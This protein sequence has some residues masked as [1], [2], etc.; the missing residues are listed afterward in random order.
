MPMKEKEKG[1]EYIGQG[2][3]GCVFDHQIKCE[4]NILISK[5]PKI[6]YSKVFDS[7]EEA[8]I[9]WKNSKIIA[10]IDPNYDS[11]VYCFEKCTTNYDEVKKD[12]SIQKC[13]LHFYENTITILKMPYGGID[14][15]KYITTQNPS[16][17][18]FI[19]SIIPLFEGL[20]KLKNINIVHQDVKADNV[21]YD[22]EKNIWRFIDY[23]ILTTTNKIYIKN[24]LHI[25][26][27]DYYPAP[28]EYR[29]LTK[30]YK[31]KNTS[32]DPNDIIANENE[33]YNLKLSSDS[34]M[35]Y[36]DLIHIYMPKIEYETSLVNFIK[37]LKNFNTTNIVSELNKYTSKI[38]IY[39]LGLV[40]MYLTLKVKIIH[41][42][43]Y[44]QKY[45]SYM[46]LIK[47]MIYPDPRRRL[48]PEEALVKIKNI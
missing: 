13:D 18:N 1:G 15:K 36:S 10:S 39:S 9:E 22:K 3:Y 28:A 23:G 7:N 32:I 34:N 14:Y 35:S 30:I 29:I 25:I 38:D 24:N 40:L 47:M 41:D 8:E 4:N 37:Y 44:E 16:F 43:E 31:F 2:S 46:E 27:G 33:I 48:T 12:K 42:I 19:Q 5:I 20:V 11:F 26:T 45:K 17:H 6:I 21:L